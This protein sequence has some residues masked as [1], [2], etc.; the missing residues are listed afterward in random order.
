MFSQLPIAGGRKSGNAAFEPDKRLALAIRLLELVGDLAEAERLREIACENRDELVDVA[1]RSRQSFAQMCDRPPTAVVRVVRAVDPRHELR[2]GLPFPLQPRSVCREPFL[3]KH[4]AVPLRR[5]QEPLPLRLELE[6]D[7]ADA[8]AARVRVPG[9]A[10]C[11]VDVLEPRDD[12]S[13]VAARVVD[14]AHRGVESRHHVLGEDD[15]VVR[16]TRCYELLE[17]VDEPV[18]PIRVFRGA[19]PSDVSRDAEL[20]REHLA[21]RL[22]VEGACRDRRLRVQ[23]GQRGLV[24]VGELEQSADELLGLERHEVVAELVS[25]WITHGSLRLV[26]DPREPGRPVE[27]HV[28]RPDDLRAAPDRPSG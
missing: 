28:G 23:G 27:L 4:V 18:D 21:E 3:T 6:L 15:D 16:A 9:E 26:H 17:Q 20:C 19:T 5:V 24:A 2:H 10:R 22:E 7:E 11:M 8:E 12:A 14:P 1:F 25:G 13:E